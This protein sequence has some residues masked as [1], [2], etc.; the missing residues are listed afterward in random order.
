[1]PW[2]W[3][4][5]IVS[6]VVGPFEAMYAYYRAKKRLEEAR[7]RQ[8]AAQGGDQNDPSS[9]SRSASMPASGGSTSSSLTP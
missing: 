9:A 8:K 4:V 5:V 7:A 3:I 6:A 1:M 2:Y